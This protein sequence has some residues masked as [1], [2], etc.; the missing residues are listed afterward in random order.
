VTEVNQASKAIRAREPR[1]YGAGWM[2]KLR[3]K[4]AGELEQLL[5]SESYKQ[6]IGQ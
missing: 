6:Q 1:P 5:N 3:A 4:N 2:L